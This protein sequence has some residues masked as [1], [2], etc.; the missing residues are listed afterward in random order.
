MQSKEFDLSL[1]WTE[2]L[3]VTDS[4]T[5]PSPGVAGAAANIRQ[6]SFLS[7]PD[8]STS[9]SAVADKLNLILYLFVESYI[10]LFILVCT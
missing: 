5:E 9:C 1:E 10:I 3:D 4:L 6:V 2:V 8:T 7:G